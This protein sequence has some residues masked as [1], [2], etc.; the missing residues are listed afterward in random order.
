MDFL[1]KYLINLWKPSFNTVDKD[2]DITLFSF[3]SVPLKWKDFDKKT[4]IK[5]KQSVVFLLKERTQKPKTN[6][7]LAEELKISN[8]LVKILLQSNLTLNEHKLLNVMFAQINPEDTEFKLLT[9]SSREIKKLCNF[10]NSDNFKRNININIYNISNMMF[11]DNKNKQFSLFATLKYN[12]NNILSFQFDNYL[13]PF[14][15]DLKENFIQKQL[16]EIQEY[17]NEYA[18]RLDMLF[19]MYFNKQ[20]SKM[21]NLKKLETKI[22]FSFSVEEIKTIL[23]I[24]DK[25]KNRF[26][27]FMSKVIVPAIE[28]INNARY[29]N[30]SYEV[31]RKNK[32]ADRL[33]FFLSLGEKSSKYKELISKIKKVSTLDKIKKIFSIVGFSENEINKITTQYSVEIL[34]QVINELKEKKNLYF[35]NQEKQEFLKKKLS[36]N[37][38]NDLDSLLNDF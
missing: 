22:R 17:K 19:T 7:Y 29:Y 31:E 38:S 35:T 30:V 4:V 9:L 32:K 25:Y 21:S 33:V 8:E 27:N 28:E 18:L 15:L 20:N 34:K 12:N 26:N 2:S 23:G 10:N 24:Q 14:L 11:I 16:K 5:P 1:E 37:N 13:K 3:N 6:H 36:I